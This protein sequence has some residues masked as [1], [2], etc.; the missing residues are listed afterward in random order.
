MKKRDGKTLTQ[1]LDL[2]TMFYL[3][4]KVQNFQLEVGSHKQSHETKEYL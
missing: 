2:I 1:Y 4:D 3:S